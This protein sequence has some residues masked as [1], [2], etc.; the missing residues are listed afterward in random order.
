MRAAQLCVADHRHTMITYLRVRFRDNP[1]ASSS[2]GSLA[3]ALRDGEDELARFLK[4]LQSTG[5][6]QPKTT[7][8]DPAPPA[9]AV[10]SAHILHPSGPSGEALNMID[11]HVSRWAESTVQEW[12]R[13]L[14]LEEHVP[15]FKRGRVDGALLLVLD[16]EDLE[17]EL[18]VVSRLQRKRLKMRIM[19]LLHTDST[20]PLP[21]Q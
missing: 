8:A 18:G 20:G 16:D 2:E 17:E 12:L 13:G 15:A 6:L 19:E 7:P 21:E 14:G 9:P 10:Y 4:T 1:A 11:A 3:R 5:R